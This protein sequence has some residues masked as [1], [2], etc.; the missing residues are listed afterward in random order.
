MYTVIS[1]SAACKIL[2]EAFWF[3]KNAPFVQ[4]NCCI[5]LTDTY[6]WLF[7]LQV[8]RLHQFFPLV[9]VQCSPYLKFFLCAMYVP[10]CTVL[11]EAI[12]PCRSLCVSART[13]CETLMNRLVNCKINGVCCK[14]KKQCYQGY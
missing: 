14:I 12:P 13:G 8:W 1:T 9:K 11:E 4:Y 2:T 7:N 10:V 6:I 5:F 3:V